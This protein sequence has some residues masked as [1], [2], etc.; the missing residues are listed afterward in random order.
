[1]KNWPFSDAENTA[2]FT[3]RQVLEEGAPILRV[4][5]DADDGSWQFHT[6]GTPRIRDARIIALSEALDIEPSIGQLADL[7]MGWQATRSSIGEEWTR[8]RKED[9]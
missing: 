5:H 1:M 6:S 9:D 7:P 4:T 8:Q 2:V 3:S